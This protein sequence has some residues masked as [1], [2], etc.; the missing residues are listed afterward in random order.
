VRR[1]V[2]LCA[3]VPEPGRSLIEPPA[4]DSPAVARQGQV[5]R[6]DG[7]VIWTAEAA[8][9]AFYHDCP[10]PVA[11]AAAARLRPQA[12][13]PLW[14]RCPLARLPEVPATY[15]LCQDDRV[16]PPEWARRHVPDRLG[17]VPLEL[18]RGHSPFLSRPEVLA[19]LLLAQL[20]T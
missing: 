15:I 7:T 6:A 18:P 14:E 8:R 5:V 20:D 19:A 2:Y 13:T 17:V 4:G 9:R 3:A 1:L 16:T 12:M 10:P 11:V